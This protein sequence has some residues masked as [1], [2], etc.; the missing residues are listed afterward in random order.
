[1]MMN[2]TTSGALNKIWEFFSRHSDDDLKVLDSL[3]QEL[4]VGDTKGVVI[5]G[6]VVVLV[7]DDLWVGVFKE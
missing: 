2:K 1:M 4:E 5:S 7:S 3:P 6:K